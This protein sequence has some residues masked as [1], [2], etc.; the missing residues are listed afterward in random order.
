MYPLAVLLPIGILRKDRA[1]ALYSLPFALAGLGLS[2]F[3]NLL[4]FGIIPEETVPC[5]AGVSCATVQPVLFGIITIPHL[6][7][8]GFLVISILLLIMLKLKPK[9]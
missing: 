8:I 1:I 5:V 6:S 7:F 4:Q 9:P 2:I 3:H